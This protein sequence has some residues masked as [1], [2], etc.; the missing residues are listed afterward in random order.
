[1]AND[2][3]V[4]SHTPE[5]SER[6][7]LGLLQR[8]LDPLS[9]RR[10]AELGILQSWRCLE[11]GAGYGSLARW[12]TDQVGPQGRVWQPTLIHASLPRLSSPTWKCESTIFAPIPWNP[13]RTIWLTAGRS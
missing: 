1:M 10:L 6:K 12:L 3:Y 5:A 11:V 2:E 4:L 13:T 9:Q 8:Q 7:R